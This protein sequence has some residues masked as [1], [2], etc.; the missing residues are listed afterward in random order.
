[1]QSHLATGRMA[2]SLAAA[3]CSQS[4]CLCRCLGASSL[5]VRAAR[6]LAHE[7]TESARQKKLEGPYP[8]D[9]LKRVTAMP[10]V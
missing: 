3:A 8:E 6:A 9:T 7:L 1:M 10:K 4:H 5:G 2:C